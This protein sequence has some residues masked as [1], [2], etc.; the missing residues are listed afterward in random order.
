MIGEI[1]LSIL[2]V[3]LAVVSVVIN[4][5][6]AFSGKRTVKVAPPKIN[7]RVRA[8]VSCKKFDP[9][10]YVIEHIGKYGVINMGVSLDRREIHICDYNAMGIEDDI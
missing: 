3:A 9:Q 2:V 10:K 8:G 1:G 5:R 4:G 7:D 6:Y